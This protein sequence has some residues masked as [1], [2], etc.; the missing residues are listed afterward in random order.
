MT[1]NILILRF[2]SWDNLA[3]MEDNYF[4][5]KFYTTNQFPLPRLVFR[6]LAA[7]LNQIIEC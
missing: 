6:R 1:E 2:L 7:M 3:I 5:N 4:M